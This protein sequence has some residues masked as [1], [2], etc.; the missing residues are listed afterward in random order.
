MSRP[1]PT[2]DRLPAG[3]VFYE[4]RRW[5]RLVGNG[6]LELIVPR[7]HENIVSGGNYADR[8]DRTARARE[9]G[10]YICLDLLAAPGWAA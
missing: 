5:W 2:A 1:D 3:T 7:G 10:C 8:S 4:R 9:C 6:F